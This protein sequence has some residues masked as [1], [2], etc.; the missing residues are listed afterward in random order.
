MNSI[1][2]SMDKTNS[3]EETRVEVEEKQVPV[4][5]KVESIKPA[6]EPVIS[7]TP[8]PNTWRPNNYHGTIIC[9]V[10]TASQKFNLRRDNLTLQSYDTFTPN[11]ALVRVLTV[12]LREVIRDL[13]TN[14]EMHQ[15]IIKRFPECNEGIGAVVNL[16]GGRDVMVQ[17]H[18]S[19]ETHRVYCCSISLCDPVRAK[20]S[21]HPSQLAQPKKTPAEVSSGKIVEAVKTKQTSPPL[22]HQ[23]SSAQA[24]QAFSYPHDI[25]AEYFQSVEPNTPVL[26]SQIFKSEHVPET[27]TNEYTPDLAGQVYQSASIPESRNSEPEPVLE[28]QSYQ[29]ASASEKWTSQSTTVPATQTNKSGPVRE[30]QTDHYEPISLPHSSLPAPTKVEH[31]PVDESFTT[32]E[33]EQEQESYVVVENTY[34]EEQTESFKVERNS[35]EE[36]TETDHVAFKTLDEINAAEHDSDP[37]ALTH[38]PWAGAIT[39]ST[40]K[41]LG[42][43]SGLPDESLVLEHVYGYRTRD[44]RNNLFCN[45]GGKIVFPAGSVCVVHDIKE[46]T[47][48]FFQEHK[49]EVTALVLHPDGKTVASGDVVTD[50]DGCFV[51]IWNSEDPED[52]TQHIQIRIGVKK[53]AKGVADVEFSPDGKYLS[54]VAKDSDHTIYIFEWE[55]SRKAAYTAKG[56]SDSVCF[57]LLPI[58]F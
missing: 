25:P 26:E 5:S 27:Q 31:Q 12:S 2:L 55:K 53:L 7:V 46:N 1:F 40:K 23:M 32:V 24:K 49:E 6:P 50:Y 30:A 45:A 28:K 29:S 33:V 44:C 37:R 9:T 41:N 36:Q 3:P 51:Y 58:P 43:K 34:H 8:T 20:S 18:A 54:V 39:Q 47:Q 52:M 11:G 35:T 10:E 42:A 48:R 56:H 17:V 15:L 14:Y 38:K 57:T 21:N 19:S 4:P 22:V 13:P 16:L